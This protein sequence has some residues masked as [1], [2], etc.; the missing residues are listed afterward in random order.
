MNTA[1]DRISQSITTT[2]D[3]KAII[4]EQIAKTPGI[5]YKELLRSTGLTNG[6]L[7]YHLKIFEKLHKVKVDRHD[8]RRTRYYPLNIST[9]ESHILGSVRN[10][11]ARKI[12][13]F[14]LGYD[15]CTFGEIVEHIKKAPSTV[16]WHLK[17][18]SE[19]GMISISYGQEYQ[20]YSIVNSNLVKE[21]L[22]KYEESFRDK[23]ANGYYEMFEEL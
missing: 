11:V 14:I 1:S 16:S 13:Y 18:L 15:L 8:G 2:V 10:S 23:I 22:F 6:T 20:L 21:V 5:R 17:R 3:T 7:E 12:V 4:L 19:A 9:D